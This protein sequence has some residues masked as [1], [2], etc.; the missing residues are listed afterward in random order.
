MRALAERELTEINEPALGI[1]RELGVILL[2]FP[3]LVQLQNQRPPR[4]DPFEPKRRTPN[5]PWKPRHRE[6]RGG[7]TSVGRDGVVRESG[8]RS[9]LA[10]LA[11]GGVLAELTIVFSGRSTPVPYK[12]LLLQA[13][14]K[15]FSLPSESRSSTI[16]TLRLTPEL[17]STEKPILFRELVGR[18]AGRKMAAARREGGKVAAA[19]REGGKAGSAWG[20]EGSN[21]GV[22]RSWAARRDDELMK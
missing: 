3:R 4:H 12:G 9:L 6:T 11:D 7:V 19:W 16:L 8:E 21:T 2:P 14:M 18:G 13:P 22:G 15:S 10:E 17:Y 5:Q 1:M 20:G